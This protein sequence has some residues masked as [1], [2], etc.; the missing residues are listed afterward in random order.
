MREEPSQVTGL[1]FADNIYRPIHCLYTSIQA[2]HQTTSM[3][4]YNLPILDQLLNL[5]K[6][7]RRLDKVQTAELCKQAASL[8]IEQTSLLVAIILC[9]KARSERMDLRSQAV[10][11]SNLYGAKQATGGNGI[12][13]FNSKLPD[14]LLLVIHTYLSLIF[15]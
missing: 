14:E 15:G 3:S 13:F 7:K 6:E 5:I 10:T 2:T 1:S 12:Y 11:E 9:Y 4:E 8:N